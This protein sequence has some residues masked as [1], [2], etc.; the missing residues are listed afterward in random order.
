MQSVDHRL[1]GGRRAPQQQSLA[2]HLLAGTMLTALAVGGGASVAAAGEQAADQ[3]LA[4]A[5]AAHDFAIAPQPLASALDR[6]A[7]RTG[8]SFAYRSSDISGLSTPGLA[9]NFTVSDGLHHLLTGTGV[10]FQF[11]SPTTVTLARAQANGAIALGTITVEARSQAGS[12]GYKADHLSS[13]RAT[14]PLLDTPQTVSVIPPA[15][16]QEQGARTLPE[17]LRNTPGISFNAGENGFGTSTNNFQIRGFDASGSLFIDGTRD[18]G[19]YTRDMFNVEQVEVAKGAAADNG[20]GNAGGYVNMVTKTPRLENF[21]AGAASLEVD[22]YDSEMRKRTSVDMNQVL[23]EGVALRLNGMLEDGGVA[24]RN[25]AEAN[26]WGIAPSLGIGLGTDFRATLAYEHYE[27]NDLPDWGVPAH[28]IKGMINYDPTAGGTNRDGF[29]GLSSDF[30]DVASDA[31]TARFE[32]DINDYLTISNQTRWTRIDRKSRFTVAAFHPASG[33]IRT[34]TLFYDRDNETLG[35]L[36]D[37]SASFTT[38]PLRHTVSTGLELTRETSASNRYSGLNAGVVSLTSPDPD[39][40]D[41]GAWP[42]PAQTADINVETVAVYAYDT[43]KLSEQW[44]V[45]GGLRAERYRVELSDSNGG[46]ANGLDLTETT[47][48][49]KIGVVY[50]PARNGSLYASFGISHQPPGSYLSNPD[51]SR[52]GNNAFPGY[53]PGA[54]PIESHNYEIGVK[55]DFLDGALGTSAAL[56]R[57]EKKDVAINGPN[58]LA[59]YGEQIVQGIEL[60]AAGRITPAWSVFGGIALVDS[61]RRH[62]AHLDQQ[63]YLSNPGDRGN[64]PTVSVNGDE[65]AFTPSLTANLWTTYQATDRLSLGGGAQY[66]GS[67]WLGRPDDA[68]RVIPNGRFGKLPSY[69]LVHAMMS[70]ELVEDVAIRFNVDNV[71]DEEYAVSANWPGT[72]AALGTPRTYRIST[73]FKF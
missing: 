67:S 73:S 34:Q 69:F 27:R 55:W 45:T 25:V 52:T 65:L 13:I 43:V 2:C 23:A 26:A 8:L 48:G 7:E 1:K 56:F 21:V 31:V 44:Q 24:G 5:G 40:F 33:E 41:P 54:K 61:E 36:T 57:T 38:G 37:L 29:Y 32:Y 58:G 59:G 18:S 14:A 47:L 53:Q 51:I 16:I 72:R 68:S 66:V 71:F 42:A 39:R 17:V 12:E 19:S 15:I 10:S 63:L 70:Y 60:G 28:T 4:Q 49:G 22:E 50:K 30:D 20:R 35:N 11:T 64:D 6:F 62:S 3:Q 46:A 9:G